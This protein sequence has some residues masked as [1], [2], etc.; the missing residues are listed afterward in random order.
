VNLSIL[1]PLRLS[2]SVRESGSSRILPA[3][4]QGGPEP[5][6]SPTQSPSHGVPWFSSYG[7][8]FNKDFGVTTERGENFGLS[9]FLREGKAVYH[10]YFTNSRGV[11]R[12]GSILTCLT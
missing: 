8:D 12:S 4:A 5:S 6:K 7:S 11:D 1:R 10:T 9:V 2:R 3:P